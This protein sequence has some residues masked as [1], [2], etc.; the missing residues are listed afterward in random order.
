[1][2]TYGCYH[3]ILV[4]NKHRILPVFFQPFEFPAPKSQRRAATSVLSKS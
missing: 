2:I 3:A 1:M 4:S